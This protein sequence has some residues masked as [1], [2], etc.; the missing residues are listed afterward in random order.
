MPIACCRLGSA[1][2]LLGVV[3]LVSGCQLAGAVAYKVAGPEEVEAKH[4][5]ARVPTLVL[6]ENYENPG[7][8]AL[9][10]EQL[11]YFVGG[12]LKDHMVAPVVDAGRLADLKA[13]HGSG[14][15]EMRVQDVGAALGAQ[16]V[17][18]V[19]MLDCRVEDT[20]GG[21]LIKASVAVRVKVVDVGSGHTVWPTDIAEGY[22]V[23][24]DTPYQREGK[25]N[26]QMALRREVLRVTGVKVAKLF[27]K[28][29]PEEGETE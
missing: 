2:G 18:Y 12:E 13:S 22:P 8:S 23:R 1:I 3:G 21:E 29:K 15:R 7:A 26:T 14:Y 6:V 11:G 16:Q 9:D 4:V 17:V 20:A 28:W 19:D 27:Y 25:R 5:L 24:L 10:S